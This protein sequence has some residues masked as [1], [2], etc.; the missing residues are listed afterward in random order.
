[1]ILYNTLS[2]LHILYILTKNPLPDCSLFLSI[3]EKK[4]EYIE[5]YI[6]HL[7][8]CEKKMECIERYIVHLN[9]CENYTKFI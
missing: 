8:K 4:M 3:V 1:M 5:R 7:N 2:N 9:K 6:V